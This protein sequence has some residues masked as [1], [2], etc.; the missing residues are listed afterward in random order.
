MDSSSLAFFASTLFVAAIIPGPGITAL[1]LRVLGY[2]SRGALGFC[3]GMALGDFTW[4]TFAV[5]GLAA[6]A[7][8]FALA[9]TIIKYVGAAY[10]VYIA[11]KMWTARDMGLEIDSSK[12]SRGSTLVGSIL[13]G[14]FL[15][16]GN[17]KVMVFYLALLPNII[18]IDQISLIGYGQLLIV[19]LSVLLVVFAIYVFLAL[20]ARRMISSN[21]VMGYVGKGSSLLMLGVAATIVTR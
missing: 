14:L 7:S 16:L 6:I 15:T 19:L 3:I 17:P 11:W 5:L 21:R 20:K 9:F 12:K 13:S 10:L 2:G 1:V 8:T 4:F 18:R